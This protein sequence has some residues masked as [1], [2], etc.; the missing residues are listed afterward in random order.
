MDTLYLDALLERVADGQTAPAD[1]EFPRQLMRTH[2]YLPQRA[3]WGRQPGT[4]V[5]QAR[6]RLHGP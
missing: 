6:G 4:R 3:Q 5:V 1:A 2:H